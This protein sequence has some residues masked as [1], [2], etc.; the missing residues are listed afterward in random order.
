MADVNIKISTVDAALTALKVALETTDAV[1]AAGIADNLTK[2]N[3]QITR[4]D[5]L[6][7][8]T[9]TGAV[10]DGQIVANRKKI[11]ALESLSN[12]A[13]ILI[14]QLLAK[15]TIDDTGYNE[16]KAIS[17]SGGGFTI[18]TGYVGMEIKIVDIEAH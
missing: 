13:S 5:G 9:D 14:N 7:A 15:T 6:L 11:I 10:A 8:D 3:Q 1:H 2:I 4:L 16:I 12:T 18:P 17:L